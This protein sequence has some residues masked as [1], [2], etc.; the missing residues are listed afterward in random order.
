MRHEPSVTTDIAG[1][2]IAFSRLIWQPKGLV[3]RSGHRGDRWSPHRLMWLLTNIRMI[4]L[5]CSQ[6]GETTD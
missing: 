6:S 4:R 1:I 5:M 2:E 3:A